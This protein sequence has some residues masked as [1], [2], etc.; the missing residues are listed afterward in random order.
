VGAA[1]VLVQVEEPR[2]QRTSS[3]SASSAIITPTLVSAAACTGSG[4]Y[5]LKTTIGSPKA[6]RLVACPRPQESP[7]RAAVRPAR[8][9]PVAI[10]VVTAAK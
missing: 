10:S 3:Q 4:R 7:R 1:V 6:N 8:S 5:A 2:R 9:R